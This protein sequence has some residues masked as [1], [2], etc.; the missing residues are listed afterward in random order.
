MKN[1]LYRQGR[2]G[3]ERRRCQ[4]SS[5]VILSH[6]GFL[7]LLTSSLEESTHEALA[8]MKQAIDTTK[9]DWG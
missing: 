1:S 4:P 7:A 9:Q 5:A 8:S 3:V 2:E 6:A